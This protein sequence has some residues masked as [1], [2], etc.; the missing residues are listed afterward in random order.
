MDKILG[1]YILVIGANHAQ[2]DLL[3]PPLFLKISIIGKF[4]LHAI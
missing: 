3:T 2:G 4:H 1:E